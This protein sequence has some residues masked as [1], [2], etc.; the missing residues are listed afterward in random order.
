MENKKW[1]EGAYIFNRDPDWNGQINMN[2]DKET[3][4]KDL[5]ETFAAYKG[6]ITDIALCVFGKGSVIPSK[7]TPWCGESW[8]KYLKVDPDGSY[9]QAPNHYKC[10]VEY[11]IDAVEVFIEEVKK[12]GIRPWLSMRMNDCH[13]SKHNIDLYYEAE[14]KGML[15]GKEY[16]YYGTCYNFAFDKYCDMTIDFIREMLSKYDV[17]GLELDFL[18]EPHCLDYKH[19]ENRWEIMTNYMRRVKATVTECEKIVGHPIKILMRHPSNPESAYD[20]GFDMKTIAAEGL[21]DVSSPGPRW[22]NCDSYIPVSEWEKIVGDDIAVIPGLEIFNVKY[23]YSQDYHLKGYMAAYKSL[24]AKAIYGYNLFWINED[25]WKNWQI[26]IDNCTEGYREFIVA[27]QDC[28]TREDMSYKPL[29]IK[30]DGTHELPL[31]IGLVKDV[32]DVKLVID[33]EGEEFPEITIDGKFTVTGKKCA[34]ILEGGGEHH[35]PVDPETG[36][37]IITSHTPIEYDLNGYSTDGPIT[38]TFK[39]KGTVSY[40]NFRIDAK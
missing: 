40:I 32:D 24:G 17:F 19:D 30:L 36:L 27:N 12:N 18:R 7:T 37:S 29:P 10:F 39:G 5:R 13:P 16:G 9:G 31:V 3:Y 1:Y 26:S 2:T 20:F 15:L 8:L 25:N 33:F 35:N 4:L 21:I 28:F 38:L 23:V 34:P 14:E 6:A 11:G 22:L